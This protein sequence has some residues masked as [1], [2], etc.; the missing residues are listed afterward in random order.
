MRKTSKSF[1]VA[2]PQ[3][4]DRVRSYDFPGTTTCWV[5]GVIVDL[6]MMESR[7]VIAVDRTVFDG[8]QIQTKPNQTV[9]PPFNGLDGIFGKTCGVT[10]I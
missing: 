10:L 2:D 5:E 3:I 7:Y 1:V 9:F 8:K 6:D 4:G